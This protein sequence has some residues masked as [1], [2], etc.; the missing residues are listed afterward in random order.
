[1]IQNYFQK[2]NYSD[3]IWYTWSAVA[4]VW[5]NFFFN[6]TFVITGVCIIFRDE[7]NFGKYV[8]PGRVASLEGGQIKHKTDSIQTMQLLMIRS[9]CWSPTQGFATD[10]Q[11]H[12]AHQLL[13]ELPTHLRSPS[14]INA[15]ALVSPVATG[16]DS[17]AVFQ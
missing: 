17:S 9:T 12:T 11:V 10:S 5:T 16:A 15:H 3:T 13:T 14:C 1:M 7:L 2:L 8:K 6:L 4:D